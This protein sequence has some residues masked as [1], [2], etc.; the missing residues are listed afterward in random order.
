MPGQPLTSAYQYL[1]L[2][3]LPGE[4]WEDIPQLDGYFCISNLGRVKREAYEMQYRNGAIYLKPEKIIK[5]QIIRQLNKLKKDFTY[6]LTARVTLSGVR[7]TISIARMVYYCFVETF[8]L[9]DPNKLVICKDCNNFNI[10][11]SNLQLITK[12]QKQKRAIVRKRFRSPL[13][14]LSAEQRQIQRKA[15]VRKVSKQV[16]QYNMKG[17]KLRTF[18]SAAE[19]ERATGIFASSVGKVAS[20]EDIRAGGFI[21]RWG[22]APAIDVEAFRKKKRAA[23]VKKYGQKVTQYD[24]S[25]RKV[26][27]Y[28]GVREASEATGTHI[29]AINK[30]LKGEYKSAKGSFWTKGYGKDFIDLSDYKWGKASMAAT[31]SKPV[32]QYGLDGKYIQ[33]FPSIKLA[34]QAVGLHS[35]SII[36][37]LKGRQHTGGGFRWKYA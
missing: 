12:S 18:S 8:D 36:D 4:E 35:A 31:Q 2:E 3:A 28:P 6:F 24:L 17:K 5:P 9:K 13:L 10:R 16:S 32:K 26:A 22:K 34:A 29:N 33:T 30:V 7:H 11:P 19:A 27:Q 20:G 23:Y 37:T 1:S 25:G 21:W 14:D 15:I